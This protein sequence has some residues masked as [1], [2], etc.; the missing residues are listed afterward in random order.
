MRMS[1][2]SRCNSKR[3]QQYRHFKSRS[4]ASVRVAMRAGAVQPNL[5]S[6]GTKLQ[7]ESSIFRSGLSMT[8]ATLAI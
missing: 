2:V 3:R 4:L 7:P 5:M 1:V 6:I 8:N